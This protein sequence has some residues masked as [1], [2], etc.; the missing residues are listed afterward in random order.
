MLEK[1]VAIIGDILVRCH[2][3]NSF[4]EISK[5][6]D[7]YGSENNFVCQNNYVKHSKWL[8]KHYNF[9]Q[10][11][12]QCLSILHNFFNDPTK[13]AKFLDISAKLFFPLNCGQFFNKFDLKYSKIQTI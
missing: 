11:Y 4:A 5:N 3:K 7:R 9:L 1:Y 10:H 13:L 2:G 8:L 6:L 12:Y